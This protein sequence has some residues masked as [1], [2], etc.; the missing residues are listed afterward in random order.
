MSSVLRKV[1]TKI[2]LQQWV[3]KY[4]QQL[5]KTPL[6]GFGSGKMSLDNTRWQ[7]VAGLFTVYSFVPFEF[8]TMYK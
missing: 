7:E 8:C 3:R 4:T 2:R 6:T 1:G 5:W